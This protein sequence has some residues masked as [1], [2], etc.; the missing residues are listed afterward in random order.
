MTGTCCNHCGAPNM[1]V[2][3]NV[4]HPIYKDMVCAATV[5]SKR[6]NPFDALRPASAPTSRESE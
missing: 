3:T 6:C 2:A 1:R 5:C 4:P